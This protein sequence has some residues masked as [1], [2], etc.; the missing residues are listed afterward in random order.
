M[1]ALRAAVDKAEGVSFLNKGEVCR[2]EV[3]RCIG[4][5]G[6]DVLGLKM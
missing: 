5:D 2:C 6:V 4:M 3:T 1:V